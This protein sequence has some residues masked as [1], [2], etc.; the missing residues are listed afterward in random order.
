MPTVGSSGRAERFKFLSFRRVRAATL[1]AL[2][3]RADGR[4]P[5][6]VGQRRFIHTNDRSYRKNSEVGS[7]DSKQ[8]YVS[9]KSTE[10][11]G[12]MDRSTLGPCRSSGLIWDRVSVARDGR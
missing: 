5:A 10:G 6:K 12:K 3:A 4:V 7:G 11:I 1:P 9:D 2:P 8:L